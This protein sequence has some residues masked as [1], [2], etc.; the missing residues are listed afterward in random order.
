MVERILAPLDGS[1]T[2]EGVLAHV[3]RL[4]RVSGSEIVLL[5]AVPVVGVDG[6][7]AVFRASVQGATDYLEGIRSRLESSGFR[8]RVIVRAGGAAETVLGVAAEL[9]A[10]LLAVATHGRTGA[11][12]LVLGSVAETLLRSTPIPV[13][14]VRPFWTYD[15]QPEGGVE[16]QPIRTI[17]L[18]VGSGERSLCVLPHAILMARL[19][20]ARV[21]ILHAR[22]AKED[23]NESLINDLA[24]RFRKEKIEATTLIEPG[25]P[26][27]TI[28]EAC[29]ARA[30]DLAVMSTHGRGGLSRL[31]LGSVTEEV[32]RQARTPLLVVRGDPSPKLPWKIAET[33]RI[34]KK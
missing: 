10:D 14:A 3:R 28:L 30:V 29:R 2:A 24:G 8:A 6:G 16:S 20:K 12:R 21:M 11:Q 13:L 9:K 25:N 19:F 22:G 5:Q 31:V 23:V 26:V 7:E 34:K 18:P 32:L 15:L 17:L 33:T 4:A 27:D 1:N